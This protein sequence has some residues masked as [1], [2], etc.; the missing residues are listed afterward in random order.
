VQ[1]AAEAAVSASATPLVRVELALSSDGTEASISVSDNG[2]GIDEEARS[3]IFD[4]FYSSKAEGMGMG[5]AICRSI[6]EAHHG[7]IE[8]LD[9]PL[10]GG[11]CFRFWIPVN[12]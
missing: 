3:R 7:R 11:A 8:L 6:L 5:L 9:G 12:E 4:A 2:A 10:H 1:N